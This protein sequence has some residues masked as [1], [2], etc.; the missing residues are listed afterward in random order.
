MI[1]AW[2]SF[3]EVVVASLVA[4]CLLVALFSL[5]LRIN[6]S[7]LTWRRLSAVALFTLCAAVVAFGIFLIVPAF[8]ANF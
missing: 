8:H 1:I 7:A 3:V 6:D 4:A 5:A 2:G